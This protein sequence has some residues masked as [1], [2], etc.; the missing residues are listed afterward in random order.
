MEITTLQSVLLVV[1]TANMVLT[2]VNYRLIREYIKELQEESLTFGLSRNIAPWWTSPS[3]S[4]SPSES[5]SFSPSPENAEDVD[6]N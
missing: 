3:P 6:D 5:F 2:F 4:Y 1:I